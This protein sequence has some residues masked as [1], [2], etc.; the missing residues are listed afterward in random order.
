[1]PVRVDILSRHAHKIEKYYLTK[2]QYKNQLKN[3]GAG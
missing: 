1:M 3:G 2:N